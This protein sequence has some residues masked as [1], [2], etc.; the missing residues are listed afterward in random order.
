M[1]F[2]VHPSIYKQF[3]GGLSKERLKRE[4]MRGDLDY[5]PES[6]EDFE[7][8]LEKE[9]KD[10]SVQYYKGAQGLVDILV[11]S[12]WTDGYCLWKEM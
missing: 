4:L 7:S 5:I 11:V 2:R 8:R 9:L 1:T 6:V 12:N 3:N 10:C